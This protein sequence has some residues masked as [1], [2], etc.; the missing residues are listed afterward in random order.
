M[1]NPIELGARSG[2]GDLHRVERH[3]AAVFDLRMRRDAAA[4]EVP[5]WEALREH[6]AAVKAHTLDHL[7]TYL[8]EFEARASQAGAVVHWASDAAALQRIVGDLMEERGVHRVVK[9]K[10]MLTEE[11]ELNT[12]LEARNI[13]VVD[14][15]LGERIVQL[16][17]ESPSHIIVPAIHCSREEIGELFHR[18]MGTPRGET[19]PE[20]LTRAA[21]R[22]LRSHFLAAQAAITGVNLAV[23]ES[24]SIVVV[25]NEGNADLGMS[26]PRLHVACVGIEK[27][28]PRMEDL[29]VFLRLLARSATGQP[30][31]A[32]TSVVTGP[33]PGAELH[34]VLVDNGRAAL[35]GQERHR[36]ALACIRCGACLN[37]CPVY[38]RAGGH[39][40]PGPIPGPIGAVL[41]PAMRPDGAS[42]PHASSLCGSCTAVCPIRI[43]LHDQLLAWRHDTN[44]PR[45]AASL[46]ARMAAWLMARPRWFRFAGRL[47]RGFWPLAS[48]RFPGNPAGGWLRTREL[49]PHPGPSFSARW[50]RERGAD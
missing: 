25:T 5:D 2:L 12:A 14:T 6:A 41:A 44:R 7:D 8:E 26:L 46:A 49:P 34:I 19:D 36:S 42:L 47:A 11:C 3:D 43:D 22:N 21:R 4:R 30:I 13:Q 38:R 31:S 29:P 50:H 33:R 17:H 9:S 40:Y 20:R 32:Y 37:T 23:A 24:G 16:R 18:H 35:L 45:S 15:D 28:I 1:T 48:R 27:L 39:A 10:S